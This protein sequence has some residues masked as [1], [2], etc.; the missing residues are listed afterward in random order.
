MRRAYDLLVA[1]RHD[2]VDA[3]CPS[4]R[5][6]R[7]DQRGSDQYECHSREQ[8]QIHSHDPEDQARQRAIHSKRN[9]HPDH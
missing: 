6:V 9:R 3:H 4:R 5:D 7:R 1:E 2:W 8:R